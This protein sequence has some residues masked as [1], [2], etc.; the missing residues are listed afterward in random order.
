MQCIHSSSLCI[1]KLSRKCRKSRAEVKRDCIIMTFLPISNNRL[2]FLVMTWA[3]WVMTTHYTVST[4][5]H[6]L[7]QTSRRL[8]LKCRRHLTMGIKWMD[9]TSQ[10]T[11]IGFSA[12]M[13]NREKEVVKASG[14][15]HLSKV[16]ALSFL[17]HSVWC[18][19]NLSPS[20]EWPSVHIFSLS[21]THF[22]FSFHLFDH[23]PAAYLFF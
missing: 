23:L 3:T 1:I 9:R 5:L 2:T 6:S 7:K 13:S 14:L 21:S 19:C 12:F 17:S 8:T 15:P 10:F 18:L 16:K 20:F 22:L 4:I 11:A